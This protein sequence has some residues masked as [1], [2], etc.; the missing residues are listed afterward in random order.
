MNKPKQSSNTK[1]DNTHNSQPN[2]LTTVNVKRTGI[3]C[4][5]LKKFKLSQLKES[6]YNPRIIDNETLQSLKNSIN[7]FGCVEPIIVN[8]RR[9]LNRIVG[10]H[11]RYKVLSELKVKECICVTVNC[12][13]SEE[14]LLNITLNNQ[15]LQGKFI[16]SIAV[17]IDELKSQLPDYLNKLDLKIEKLREQIGK[18]EKKT[19]PAYA[20]ETIKP[21]K[22][23]HVLLSF[24]PKLLVK[25]L[26]HLESIL[27][28]KG[29]QYEQGSN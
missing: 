22:K 28:V 25:I 5:G 23:T 7:H 1:R 4:P 26:P 11:Q 3:G 14:K 21:Y 10:G 13:Q 15:H 9:G 19:K 12:S 20:E 16:D 2:N 8:V 6:E 17:Y 27:K 29:V 24:E 18:N